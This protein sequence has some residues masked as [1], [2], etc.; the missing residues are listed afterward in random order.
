MSKK[1]IFALVVMLLILVP[2]VFIPPNPQAHVP[3]S[4]VLKS[5]A[6]FPSSLEFI[7]DDAF[8]G[9][10][11]R[12]AVFEDRLVHIGSSAF[13]NS[14]DL[15]D[16]YIPQSTYFIGP[17]AFPTPA[18]I[19]GVKK[20]YA[21]TWAEEN[22]YRFVEDDIWY[23]RGEAPSIRLEPLLIMLW[24]VFPADFEKCFLR[25]RRRTEYVRN[26]RPQERPELYPIN[27]R[28]P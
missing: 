5:A 25:W 26:M 15:K 7:F 21:Q 6:M 10:A 20:S 22:G 3:R 23:A 2:L 12:S 17:D 16:I 1:S 13:Q 14:E 8:F 11:F 9:T 18:V 4:D 27:Y 24:F 28:F 19:H